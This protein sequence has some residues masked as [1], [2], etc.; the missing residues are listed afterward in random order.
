MRKN[1]LIGELLRNPVDFDSQGRAYQLLQDYFVGLSVETLSPLLLH[2]DGCVRRSA[3]FVA[4][5]LGGRVQQIID[6]IVPLVHDPDPR[7]AW[8]AMESVMLCSNGAKVEYFAVIVRELENESGSL[9]THRE[10]KCCAT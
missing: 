2:Q 5:E 6:H 9:K 1:K 3:I 7:I 4:S 8:D 10:S